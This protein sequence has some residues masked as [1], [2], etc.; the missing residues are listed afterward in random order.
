MVERPKKH[1]KTFYD[2]N[3][4]SE[5][6]QQK[7]GY[8]ERDVAGAITKDGIDKTKPYQDFFR[9]LINHFDINS[10]TFFDFCEGD[11][12]YEEEWIQTIY[13]RYVDEFAEDGTCEMFI[14]W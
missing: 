14:W 4:C 13:N 11:A 2:Y 12:L 6:L 8:N 1:T 9:W 7:Y 5:Y 3:E 10:G